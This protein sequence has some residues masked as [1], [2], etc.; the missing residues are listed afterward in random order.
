MSTSYQNG[1]ERAALGFVEIAL[2]NNPPEDGDYY[3]KEGIL[4]CGKC[5]TPRRDFV[6]ILKNGSRVEVA[7]NCK[8][9]A[10]QEDAK[11][12]Q[13][14]CIEK[15]KRITLLKSKSR[16]S[17][18][19]KSAT[20]ET[21]YETEDRKAVM[22]CKHYAEN[23]ESF[24]EKDKGLLLYGT[25]GNGKTFTASC[26][27]NHLLD[28]LH[29]VLATSFVEMLDKFSS[30]NDDG[31]KGEYRDRLESVELLL[32]DDMGAERTTEYALE[33]I[34]RIIDKRY[35]CL[36]PVIITTNLDINDMLTCTDRSLK[37]IYDRLFEICYTVEFKGPSLRVQMA[38][39]GYEEMQKILEENT[40]E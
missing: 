13:E 16:I 1:W 22:F 19:Y 11:K 7:I 15:Q 35:Q 2:E 31:D 4:M 30:F 12:L 9:R 3:S 28:N 14:K 38:A 26:V 5:R 27:C 33:T 17:D 6:D 32:I 20:F 18:K 36:K 8:C 25:N 10:E 39:K 24:K 37:R 40:D 21:A 23:F 29:S 34:Y